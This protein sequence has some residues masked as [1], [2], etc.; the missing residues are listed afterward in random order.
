MIRLEEASRIF[1]DGAKT[2]RALQDITLHI[3]RGAIV[4]LTGESGSGKSTL[5]HLMAGLERP[6]AGRVIVAGENLN[7]LGDTALSRF[8]LTRVGFIFQF[9]HLIPSLTV[10]ENLLLPVELAGAPLRDARSRAEQGL[11]K[12]GLSDRRGAYPE[13][14]S[15]GEQQRVAVVRSLILE[16]PILFADEPTGSLDSETGAAVLSLIFDL[17]AE[18]E[19]TVV[20]A[21]HNQGLA[22]RASRRIELRDGRIHGDTGASPDGGAPAAEA[23]ANGP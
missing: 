20:L 4:A 23:A 21:T 16:P 15:G 13:R 22:A 3:P 11:K 1:Q 9:F 5:L 14:L 8:R 17:A 7:R 18:Q 6:S 12:I 2:V 19:T 10:M